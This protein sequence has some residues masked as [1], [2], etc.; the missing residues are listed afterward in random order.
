MLIPSEK[1]MAT[2]FQ[3]QIHLWFG[4]K[5]QVHRVTGGGTGWWD[6]AGSVDNN[7]YK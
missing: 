7:Q 1:S 3:A 2:A 5:F 4:P 6:N